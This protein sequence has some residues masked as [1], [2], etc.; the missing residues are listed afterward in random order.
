MPLIRAMAFFYY[1]TY[2]DLLALTGASMT[3][4]QQIKAIY[5]VLKEAL[6]DEFSA[7]DVREEVMKSG[8]AAIVRVLGKLPEET[9]GLL[10][11]IFQ[12]SGNGSNK[13]GRAAHQ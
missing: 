10:S 8:N 6:G 11:D 7:G 12:R 4:S 13:S 2:A 3:R 9:W 1:S 5:R